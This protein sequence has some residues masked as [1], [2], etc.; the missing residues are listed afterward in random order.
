ME[1]INEVFGDEVVVHL[2]QLTEEQKLEMEHTTK[3]VSGSVSH[4]EEKNH[5]ASPKTEAEVV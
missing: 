3:P 5:D 2:H 4:L 1:E